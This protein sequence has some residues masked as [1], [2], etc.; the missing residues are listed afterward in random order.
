MKLLK[1]MLI[2]TL[3]FAFVGNINAQT[4]RSHPKKLLFLGDSFTV[5]TGLE[6]DEEH[7][8]F[9]H[10]L[11]GKLKANH[12]LVGAPKIFAVDGD[13][14]KHLLGGL[15][16]VLPH[17]NPDNPTFGSGDYDLVVLS[18]GINDVFRGHALADYKHH[19][20]EIL[21]RAIRFADDDPTKVIVLSIPAWDASPSVYNQSG[22]QFRYQKYEQV[23]IKT[24][25]VYIPIEDINISGKKITIKTDAKSFSE[26]VEAAKAYNTQQGVADNI[27]NFNKAAYEI[28]KKSKVY[29]LDLTALTRIKPTI[30]NNNYNVMFAKD[31]IHYS[32]KMYEKWTEN[33]YPVAYEILS[34]DV[35][36]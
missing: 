26:K 34:E 5:G 2:S 18:I 8:A 23:R 20:E 21:K 36:R 11:A 7:L 27:D 22:T 25:E 19:F 30:E 35:K 1:N 12:V 14:T 28:A 13:T 10:Q 29:F 6:D 16:A 9:P 24:N 33:I 31:G 4:S 17:S 32:A 15:N 3:C